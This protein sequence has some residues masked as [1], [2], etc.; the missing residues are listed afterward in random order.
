MGLVSLEVKSPYL[1]G[2]ITPFRT[3]DG[4]HCGFVRIFTVRTFGVGD[5]GAQ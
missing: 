5:D 3:G 4:A 2:I 1:H